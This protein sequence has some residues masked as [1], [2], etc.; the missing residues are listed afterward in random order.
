M[1][2]AWLG[3]HW[4]GSF[5]IWSAKSRSFLDLFVGGRE[6]HFSLSCSLGLDTTEDQQEEHLPAD[7]CR[8]I[9]LVRGCLDPAS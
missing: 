4:S 5:T 9:S 1:S 2:S 3:G 8:V 7:L 6:M